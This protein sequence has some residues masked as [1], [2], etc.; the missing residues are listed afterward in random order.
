MKL[1]TLIRYQKAFDLLK[2]FEMDKAPI[3]GQDYVEIVKARCAFDL[4]LDDD[5]SAMKVD[6]DAQRYKFLRD[7][8]ALKAADDKAE[9]AKLAE[10]TGTDF[11]KAIDNA[12]EAV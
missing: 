4:E 10:L 1:S 8:F 3:S 2:R 6:I 11:D 5:L 7:E 12:M 9:F